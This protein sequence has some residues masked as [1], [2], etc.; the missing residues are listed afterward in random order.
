MYDAQQ[1]RTTVT[2]LT[3]LSCTAVCAQEQLPTDN[4][5]PAPIVQTGTPAAAPAPELSPG[6]SRIRAGI[7]LLVKLH[8]SMARVQD[9]DTAEA[10][11]PTIM[12]LSR[13]LQTWGQGFAAL[14]PLDEDTQSS[15]EKRYLPIIN[16]INE[17]IQIQADRIAAAEFYGSKNL[18]AALVKLVNSVQ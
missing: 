4:Q 10:A 18:P 5:E 15:Y 1:V 7:M 12:Q 17:S 11:V 16:K 14:P 13:E 8:D 9:H 3:L 2:L 6:E